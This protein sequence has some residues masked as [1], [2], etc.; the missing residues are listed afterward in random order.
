MWWHVYRAKN[1]SARSIGWIGTATA[2]AHKP[3]QAGE[4]GE[5]AII[6]SD[7]EELSADNW[8]NSSD[9]DDLRG[10]EV[11]TRISVPAYQT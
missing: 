4:F 1:V 10:S 3:R 7:S 11:P 9:E 5:A 8:R 2:M 6:G